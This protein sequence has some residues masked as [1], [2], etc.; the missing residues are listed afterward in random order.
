MHRVVK[1]C[2]FPFYCFCTV[3]YC[4]MYRVFELYVPSRPTVSVLYYPVLCTE[5]LSYVAFRVSVLYCTV[6]CTGLLSNVAFHPTVS[7]LY[8]TILCTGLLSYVA[9]RV[10]VLYYT[11]L[12][13]GLLS[14]VA[15]RPTVSG[16]GL[17]SSSH[18]GL[19]M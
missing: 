8:Y 3:L 7:V 15:F 17:E 9:F 12:C 14:Y 2:S 10:S 16:I 1:L 13:T 18:L 11:V 4:F 5:L 6:L 19:M